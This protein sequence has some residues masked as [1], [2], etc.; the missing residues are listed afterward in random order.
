M[1][2]ERPK[3]PKDTPAWR[4]PVGLGFRAH[5]GVLLLRFR[6]GALASIMLSD[7]TPS[8]FCWDQTAGETA[9]PR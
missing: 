3:T 1:T 4:D 9:S 5:R 8:P 6:S 7:A 2:N